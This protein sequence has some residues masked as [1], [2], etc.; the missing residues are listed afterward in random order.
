MT[1]PACAR[2]DIVCGGGCSSAA[3]AKTGAGAA[4]SA[5]ELPALSLEKLQEQ[6]RQ[7]EAEQLQQLQQQ[8]LQQNPELLALYQTLVG[9]TD[10]FQGDEGV[11]HKGLSSAEFWRLHQQQL[12]AFK[13][14]P[15]RKL[16]FKK[17]K[18]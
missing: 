13:P 3:K 10:G 4:A 12:Q 15:A 2:L 1:G 8:L 11:S 6:Q 17:F 9:P 16:N 5:V 14:Q 18:L 7:K